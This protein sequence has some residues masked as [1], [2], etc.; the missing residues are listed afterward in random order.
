MPLGRCASEVAKVAH[1]AEYFRARRAQK[2]ASA[3]EAGTS[4]PHIGRPPL[5]DTDDIP[6]E[7]YVRGKILRAMMRTP[8]ALWKPEWLSDVQGVQQEAD[9]V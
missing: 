6:A 3:L 7:V 4:L 9:R 2:R 8:P 5:S 1:T